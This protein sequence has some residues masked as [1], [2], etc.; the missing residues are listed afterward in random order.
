[1]NFKDLNNKLKAR[2]MAVKGNELALQLKY[3]DAIEYFTDAIKF[4]SSDIKIYSNRSYCY[5]KLGS[6]EK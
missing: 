2:S 5:D 6:F 4:D 1:L 3:L